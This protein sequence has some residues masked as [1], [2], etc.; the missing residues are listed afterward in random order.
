MKQVRNKQ[1]LRVAAAAAICLHAT[2]KDISRLQVRIAVKL[3]CCFRCMFIAA[4]DTADPEVLD[5]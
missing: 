4:S 5:C 1:D 3:A 2:G